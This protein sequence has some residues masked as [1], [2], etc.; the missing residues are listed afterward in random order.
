[1]YW[2]N[3]ITIEILPFSQYHID[4]RVKEGDNEPWRLTCVYGEAQVSQRFKTWD[5]LKHIKSSNPLPW[6]CIGDFNEVLHQH[7]HEGTA[8]RSLAQIAGFR[9]TTDVCGLADLGYEGRSWI[10]EKRVVGGSFC[11][12]R[13]D[14]ALATTTCS[15][16]FSLATVTNLTGVTSDHGPILL[17]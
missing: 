3:D 12:V 9:E 14:R 10:Y 11:R 17:R 6:L 5:M 7:E 16:R 8:E 1:M 4:A 15:S 2:N 13:L